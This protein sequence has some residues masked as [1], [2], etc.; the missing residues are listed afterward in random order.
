MRTVPSRFHSFSP[1]AFLLATVSFFDETGGV[2][3]PTRYINKNKKVSYK[4]GLSRI[5]F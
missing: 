4:P 2:D 5:R 3:P 1:F